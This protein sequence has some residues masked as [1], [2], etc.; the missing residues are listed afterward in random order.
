[1]VRIWARV[2][3]FYEP[4]HQEFAHFPQYIALFAAGTMAHR[5]RWVDALSDRQARTWGWIMLTCLLLLIP[6]LIAFGALSGDV[7]EGAG[8]GLAWGS[9]VYSVWEG[10]IGVAICITLL[11]WFQ[12]RSNGHGQLAEAMAGSTFD[13]YVLHPAIIV[14]FTLAISGVR[15]NPSL[16]YL[17]AAPIAITLCYL[18]VCVLRKAP[19]VR[20]ILG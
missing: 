19:V 12:R 5:H 1:V 17:L 16:K 10:F 7:A 20:A 13:V 8:G 14:P 18:V 2:L 6:L 3:V 11:A 9:L 15:L 4:C